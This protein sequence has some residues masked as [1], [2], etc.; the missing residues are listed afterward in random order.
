V[1]LGLTVKWAP[2]NLGATEPEQYGYYFARG[3]TE[4]KYNYYWTSYKLCNDS[5]YRSLTKYCPSDKTDYWG[6]SGSPDSN[7][8]LDPEDDAASANWGGRWHIPTKAELEELINNCTRIW[9]TQNGINVHVR[10][11]REEDQIPSGKVGESRAYIINQNMKRDYFEGADVAVTICA[12][13]GTIMDMN[14]KSRKTFLKPGQD[15]IIG[16]NVLDCHPEPARSM[17]ADMLENPRTN[18]YTVEKEG[19]KKL[20]FQTPWL[21][22][23]EYAGFMDLSMVLPENIPNRVRVPKK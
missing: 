18:V 20:I 22:G 17:L 11:N 4:P 8:E 23:G 19:L 12:K 21:D 2:Y 9:T 13:D 3:E 5:S 10:R 14:G 7:T 6:Y 16:K 15:E 1:D